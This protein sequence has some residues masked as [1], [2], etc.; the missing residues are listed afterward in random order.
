M[1]VWSDAIDDFPSCLKRWPSVG[2]KQSPANQRT[3]GL[4]LQQITQYR[5]QRID[6]NSTLFT[7]KQHV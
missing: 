1:L 4:L 2:F 5:L 6:I 3:V 7:W